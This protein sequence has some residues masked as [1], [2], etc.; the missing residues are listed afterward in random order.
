M[1]MHNKIALKIVLSG[2]ILAGSITCGLVDHVSAGSV[3][4]SFG[5]DAVVRQ[6]IKEMVSQVELL[7]QRAEP[8]PT[9]ART[10]I[11]GELRSVEEKL[12]DKITLTMP[13][14]DID[15][16]KSRL[17][18]VSSTIARHS[19]PGRQFLIW[20]MSPWQDYGHYAIPTTSVD[21]SAKLD[22]STC[23]NEY[24]SVTFMITN[25]SVADGAFRIHAPSLGDGRVIKAEV[26]IRSAYSVAAASGS[27]WS[28]LALPACED[29][30]IRIPKGQTG[31]VWLTLKIGEDAQPG[32]SNHTIQVIPVAQ[33]SSVD[34]ITLRLKVFPL[35]FPGKTGI[36]ACSVA[37]LVPNDPCRIHL[38]NV[39]DDAVKDLHNHYE[40]HFVMA[41]YYTPL[42]KKLDA[43]GNIVSLNFSRLDQGLELYKEADFYVFCWGLGRDLMKDLYSTGKPYPSPEWKKSFS[44]WLTMWVDY[45]KQRGIG[46]DRFA[47]FPIDE[48]PSDELAE[49]SKAIKEVDPRIK[50]FAT[51]GFW[52]YSM[53]DLKRIAPYVD[54]LSISQVSK[55]EKLDYLRS[56]GMKVWPENQPNPSKSLHPYTFRWTMWKWFDL[57]LDGCQAW[58]YN[59]ASG[60]GS[61]WDDFD[62][63]HPD[64]NFVF[65]GA[66][67]PFAT[68]ESIISSKHWEAWREGIQDWYWLRLLRKLIDDAQKGGL[69]RSMVDKASA[70][71][72]TEVRAVVDNKD[73]PDLAEKARVRVLEKII[74]L[75]SYGRVVK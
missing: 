48:R 61:L 67:A 50:V 34:V 55:G 71:L 25:I 3:A 65:D 22:V 6:Q 30:I 60:P 46:Y 17:D 21:K 35:T 29:G 9:E 26:A 32:T 58:A 41:P 15:L 31:Q 72:N 54:I 16:L 59:H 12:K 56:R 7:R 49:I 70:F 33:A 39:R 8:I 20:T 40:T 19:F 63:L 18:V 2:L 10:E 11:F 43:T 64:E 37:Y 45:L 47:M 74:E 53:D 5:Y 57:G 66:T 28:P 68:K 27:A 75:K 23:R 52:Y 14:R 24:V 44:T 13:R 73:Q 42:P 36:D 62:G 38:W 51:I 4:F 69:D 1:K